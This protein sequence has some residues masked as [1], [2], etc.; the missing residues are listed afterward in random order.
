MHM[1]RC[2]LLT[3]ETTRPMHFAVQD[4]NALLALHLKIR[5][6][7]TFVC[8]PHEQQDASTFYVRCNELHLQQLVLL[9][10]EQEFVHQL[11]EICMW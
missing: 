1:C 8:S 3:T 5:T 11:D 6:R 2:V 10:I 7:K 9:P 4:A